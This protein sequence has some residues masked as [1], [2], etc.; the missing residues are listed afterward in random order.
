V[1]SVGELIQRGWF[2]GDLL[3]SAAGVDDILEAWGQIPGVRAIN[4]DVRRTT[5][6]ESINLARLQRAPTTVR[7]DVLVH[8]ELHRLPR[9]VVDGD[10]F[11]AEQVRIEEA[12]LTLF[13]ILNGLQHSLRVFDHASC[14][15]RH[16]SLGCRGRGDA[17]R[18]GAL[19]AM[20]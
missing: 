7:K 3:H 10:G 1:R 17:I 13:K 19:P 15:V 5:P 4:E 6:A 2:S 16:A 9:I 14:R 20:R 12:S 18:G 11:L 8:L